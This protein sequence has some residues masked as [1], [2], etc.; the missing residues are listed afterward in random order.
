MFCTKS[1]IEEK[2]LN[3]SRLNDC[4]VFIQNVSY[5]H[6]T[7]ENAQTHFK[8]IVVASTFA[9][10]PLIDR[11]R[12]IYQALGKEVMTN[13]HALSIH[14]YTPE[15]WAKHNTN[16]PEPPPCRGGEAKNKAV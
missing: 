2:I 15:Q 1:L 12:I 10:L 9:S 6:N 8:V 16:C 13:I 14:C 11:H 4:L 7:P 3:Y 5:M